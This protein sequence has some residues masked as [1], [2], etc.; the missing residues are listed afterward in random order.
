MHEKGT[1]DLHDGSELAVTPEGIVVSVSVCHVNL[2]T[3]V[4]SV[5]MRSHVDLLSLQTG[6]AV[7]VSACRVNL[8][9]AHRDCALSVSARPCE[10]GN[11]SYDVLQDGVLDG[12]AK[13]H[14]GEF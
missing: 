10:P 12:R 1:R 7:S 5:V 9:A 14:S 2:V 3:V 6:C 4:W 13:T 8:V 11:L